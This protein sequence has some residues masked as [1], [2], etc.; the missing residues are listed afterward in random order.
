MKK[1]ALTSL[2]EQLNPHLPEVRVKLPM[3]V[4]PPF[5]E[6]LKALYFEHSVSDK[7]RFYLWVFFIPLCV[8]TQHVTLSLGRRIG[9]KDQRW[10][11]KDPRLVEKIALSIKSDALPFLKCVQ[12]PHEAAR[13]ALS[14]GGAAKSP[15]A[16]QANAY[17]LVQAGET[18]E[19]F[20]SLDELLD[21][22]N[23]AE[24]FDVPWPREMVARAQRL[25]ALLHKIPAAAV[26]QLQ[27]WESE[28]VHNLGLE[29][30]GFSIAAK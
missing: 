17:L 29:K 7:D 24:E 13:F 2:V 16:Q 5:R 30:I 14:V 21:L 4:F 8:P 28:S 9:G 12:E 22:L 3:I 10:D 19:A 18:N 1:N 6:I 20:K 23:V 25:K 15:F 11:F 27:D 26:A